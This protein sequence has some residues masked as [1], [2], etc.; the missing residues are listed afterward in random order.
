MK[1]ELKGIQDYYAAEAL[2]ELGAMIENNEIL[3]K[4]YDGEEETVEVEGT[5]FMAIIKKD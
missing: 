4:F 1:I 2:F 5:C 3:D